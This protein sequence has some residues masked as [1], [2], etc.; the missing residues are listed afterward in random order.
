[1]G[2]GVMAYAPLATGLL[3]G[4]Y[5]PGQEAPAGTLWG[6]RRRGHLERA[7]SGQP[8]EVL[9]AVREVAA[10]SGATVAQVALK[11]VVSRPEITVAIS[12]ADSDAQMD[13]NLG[14]VEA[15]IAPED[16]D[17]LDRV[18]AGLGMG[19]DGPQYAR[20]AR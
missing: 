3:S 14:A 8:A 12:G 10:R 2:L 15:A 17:L 11:W 16:L 4:A 1:M 18:S 19:L 7:L 5:T 6:E 20:P 9:T 13:E